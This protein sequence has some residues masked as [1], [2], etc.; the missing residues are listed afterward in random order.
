LLI[1]EVADM[2]SRA[3]V[4]LSLIVLLST[5]VAGCGTGG[6]PSVSIKIENA[7][8]LGGI[9]FS[10]LYDSSVLEVTGIRQGALARSRG[11]K[12]G[13]PKAG[14]IQVLVD[15]GSGISGDG[16]LVKVEYKVLNSTGTS[17]LVI[18][19]L[20]ARSAETGELLETHVTEGTFGA[21]GKSVVAPVISFGA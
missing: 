16:T 2:R 3:V 15:T 19:V 18:Q 21:S 6:A 13:I 17:T 1:A 14:E 5:L 4:C 10:L 11:M 8:H 20:E 7:D 9:Y 12:M